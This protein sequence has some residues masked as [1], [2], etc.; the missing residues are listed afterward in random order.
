MKLSD[1]VVEELIDRIT[2]QKKYKPGDKLPNEN[3]LALSLGVSRTT[4]RDGIHSLV[5]QGI[6]EI[7]RGKGTF[8][9]EKSEAAEEFE[10]DKLKLLHIKI[11]DLYELRLMLEPQLAFYA[12]SRATDEE[13]EEILMLGKKIEDNS[14]IKDEDS[15]GN[16]LF[17]NA[18]AKATHNEFC[19]KLMDIINGALI[20]GFKRSKLKQTLYGDILLD[21][22]MIMNY[23]KMR[24]GE[25][26]KQAMFLH[27][28]HSIKDYDI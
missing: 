27:M 15:H 8:V 19:I 13:M 22:R 28:K 4:L 3:E 17:H 5:A 14:D 23:L 16:M 1:K 20:Q 10:F 26:A 11:K 2:V 18:I 21:H 9:V 7:R 25:G 12:A 6:L 24:D